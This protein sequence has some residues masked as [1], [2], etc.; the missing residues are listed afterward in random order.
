[1]LIQPLFIPKVRSVWAVIAYVVLSRV[2]NML[3][4]RIG[5]AKGPLA[6]R[7]VRVWVLSLIMLLEGLEALKGPIARGTILH[8][9]LSF[10]L[11]SI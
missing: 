4:L 10:S 9:A 5:V 7:T 6:T 1:M 2:S 3:L 11:R 8:H